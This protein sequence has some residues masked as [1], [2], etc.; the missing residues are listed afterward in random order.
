MQ[1]QDAIDSVFAG[2]PHLMQ[3]HS[4]S[5]FRHRKYNKNMSD[6]NTGS[7]KSKN[8]ENDKL[9]LFSQRKNVDNKDESNFYKEFLEKITLERNEVQAA[10]VNTASHENEKNN[11]DTPIT[12][13]RPNLKVNLLR[14]PTKHKSNKISFGCNK[15]ATPQVPNSGR[16]ILKGNLV[17]DNIS[18]GMGNTYMS[19]SNNN[20]NPNNNNGSNANNTP[21][22]EN[23]KQFSPIT[24]QKKL[25]NNAI[26]KPFLLKREKS[27]K[28]IGGTKRPFNFVGEN[29][30]DVNNPPKKKQTVVNNINSNNYLNGTNLSSGSPKLKEK[31][32]NKPNPQLKSIYETKF[33]HVSSKEDS[34]RNNKN[35][36]SNQL[37]LNYFPESK[38]II[39]LNVNELEIKSKMKIPVFNI[40]NSW[41]KPNYLQIEKINGGCFSGTFSESNQNTYTNYEEC[42]Q[43]KDNNVINN[44][45]IKNV[46]TTHKKKQ[47]SN[48]E[49]N[50]I[51]I[52]NHHTLSL[53]PNQKQ[54]IF[55]CF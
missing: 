3:S 28:F 20:F 13:K 45:I 54:K 39:E 2:E 49:I 22:L 52:Y 31:L 35:E 40:S 16:P 33:S 12:P 53:T 24:L 6:K 19:N 4:K 51:D 25:T 9:Q 5:S 47:T 34:L 11:A 55:C 48:P 41:K 46:V 1:I 26:K 36:S 10:F 27:Q 30:K 32:F 37:E 17:K 15:Y 14:S 21:I 23:S 42:S 38:R 43:K 29:N 8:K 7:L 18:N 50:H 44:I